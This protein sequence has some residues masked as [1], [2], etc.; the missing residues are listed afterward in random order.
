MTWIWLLVSLSALVM[1]A[2]GHFRKSGN[3][4]A[5]KRSLLVLAIVPEGEALRPSAEWVAQCLREELNLEVELQKAPLPL[6]GAYLSGA[7]QQGDAVAIVGLLERLVHADRA[8]LGVIDCD[9]Y[10]SLRRDL[11][12]AMGARKGLAGLL[13]TYRMEDRVRPHNSL[14]RL[15]KMSLRYGLELACDAPR[16]RNP[17]SL[18]YESLHRC[19]QLDIMQWGDG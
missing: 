8:V 10:S 17:Q 9:L 11:P 3:P 19:E 7:A 1:T 16:N 4:L 13:S 18:H 5:P 12:Y 2:A 6:S 15:R 14:E